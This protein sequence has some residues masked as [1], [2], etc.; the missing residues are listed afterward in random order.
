MLAI[1]IT[2]WALIIAIGLM[3]AYFAIRPTPNK[4]FYKKGGFI[5]FLLFAANFAQAQLIVSE[6]QICLTGNDKVIE[7]TL[8]IA[9]TGDSVFIYR[10]EQPHHA[11][12]MR[13]IRRKSYGFNVRFGHKAANFLKVYLDKQGFPD[14][15][16]LRIGEIDYFLAI[17]PQIGL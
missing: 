4:T 10:P 13:K 5:P 17:K 8:K 6:K 16:F 3:F 2:V 1:Q 14:V 15:A 7:E 12:P 9:I 11:Y